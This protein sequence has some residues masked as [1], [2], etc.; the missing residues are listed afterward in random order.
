MRARCYPFNMRGH[1]FHGLK[2]RMHSKPHRYTAFIQQLSRL[3]MGYPMFIQYLSTV[4]IVPS[5]PFTFM[6][7]PP[8]PMSSPILFVAPCQHV[9]GRNPLFRE[10][11]PCF[12]TGTRHVLFPST[13]T[14]STNGSNFQMAAQIRPTQQAGRGAMCTR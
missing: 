11:S 9:R 4:V 2:R 1:R 10:S 7:R 8:R 14:V 5:Y 13:S 12:W 3:H 6:S